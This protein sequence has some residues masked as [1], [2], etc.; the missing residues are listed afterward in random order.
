MS[1]AD[2]SIRRDTDGNPVW[3]FRVT[4]ALLQSNRRTA[5]PREVAAHLGCSALTRVAVE[6]PAGCR[7]LKVCLEPGD[8]PQ[9]VVLDLAE[10][11]K[12]IGILNEQLIDLVVTAKRQVVL[13]PSLTSDR[14]DPEDMPHDTRDPSDDTP[15]GVRLNR[16]VANADAVAT[17][18]AAEL[19]ASVLPRWSL[20]IRS[21]AVTRDAAELIVAAA[22]EFRGAATL[23]DLLRL[24]LSDLIAAAATDSALDEVPLDDEA[25]RLAARTVGAVDACLRRLSDTEQLVALKRV[26]ANAPK[27][28]QEIASLVGLSRERI[29]QLDKKVRAALEEAARPELGLLSLVASSRLGATTTRPEIEN[30]VTD[31]LPSSD[32]N[33][34]EAE[35][36]T[37]SRRMLLNRLGYECRDGLCL[38][39]SAAATATAIKA[40]GRDMADDA[41]LIDDE[42]LRE[43]I[44]PELRDDA[45]SLVRWIGWPRLSGRVALR[46]THRARTKAGLLKLGAP[47]TKAEIAEMGGLTERQVGGALSNLPSVA[48]A[49]KS[50]WGLREWIDDVYEGIPAEIVQRINEDGGSTRLNRLLEELP[51][52]FKVSETSIWAYLN[53]PAF[54]V[55]HGWVTETT[56]SEFQTGRLVDVVDGFTDD[57]DPYWTFEVAQRHL[58]GHSLHGVPP[59]VAAALGCTFGS[60]TTASVRSPDGCPDISV[61]WRKTSMHGPE[62]GRLRP[63]L[64]ALGARDAISARLIIYDDRNIS[65]Q[66]PEQGQQQADGTPPVEGPL[67]GRHPAGG[68][69]FAGVRSAAPFHASLHRSSLAPTNDQIDVAAS[70]GVGPDTEA[71]KSDADLEAL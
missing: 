10:P 25:P 48:R 63:A 17:S 41:G 45:D 65:L 44:G 56:A 40:R 38:S 53:T 49:D 26:V 39:V 71:R 20:A 64:Q 50:R 12:R 22:R 47:A 3:T 51:R 21:T 46:D 62:I 23:G 19:L 59:E 37:A 16:T 11:L 5:F 70:S 13:R 52:L 60:R 54:R 57:G 42:L 18:D 24:D 68:R 31:L 9:T 66:L 61:I 8:P 55:D 28:L 58:E 6:D 67:D 2:V 43:E 35:S 4:E 30:V 29:R 15:Q 27:S 14:S 32:A 1:S 33:D 7:K 69:R 34:G 36:L